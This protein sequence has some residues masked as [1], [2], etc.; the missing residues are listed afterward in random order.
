[1]DTKTLLFLP[2]SA[3]SGEVSFFG[4]MLEVF[5]VANFRTAKQPF[6]C[7][8]RLDFWNINL[9]VKF[10]CPV[11]ATVFP[12]TLVQ[13]GDTIVG[14]IVGK[15]P[16]RSGSS[17]AAVYELLVNMRAFFTFSSC[18]SNFD[19]T[20]RLFSESSLSFEV[21]PFLNF[22]AADCSGMKKIGAFLS[23]GLY[24]LV[25]DGQ[26]EFS[27][28]QFQLD[29]RCEGFRGFAFCNFGAKFVLLFVTVSEWFVTVR[30]CLC[31]VLMTLCWH[32]DVL[33]AVLFIVLMY[34][35]SVR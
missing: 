6:Y 34:C 30:K 26:F 19:A 21:N 28:G 20:L 2:S 32:V 3:L 31:G 11:L 8:R 25:I 4:Q 29:I 16:L 23:A 22:N 5:S 9:T 10:L 33:V 1:M 14:S 24:Y 13:C 27:E 15:T 18:Q 7:P 12:P 17:S 35:V